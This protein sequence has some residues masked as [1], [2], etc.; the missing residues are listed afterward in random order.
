[1][2]LQSV[3]RQSLL[4]SKLSAD[5]HQLSNKLD[6]MSVRVN[7][8]PNDGDVRVQCNSSSQEVDD[9]ITSDYALSDSKVHTIK[10][11]SN[12]AGHF[13]SNLVKRLFAE[14]FGIVNYK[15][16][17]NWYGHG[18]LGKKELCR[19][20]KSL[21]RQYVVRYFPE[22]K[23]EASFKDCI[24]PKVNEL[25]RRKDKGKEKENMMG[26]LDENASFSFFLTYLNC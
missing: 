14:L 20:R 22:H 7:E 25:L 8:I 6:S 18:I 10:S 13:A 4:L 17:H 26:P 12:N 5:F 2:L 3:E 9:V 24:V 11:D 21:V 19:E 16:Q 15:L 1:M 23:Q